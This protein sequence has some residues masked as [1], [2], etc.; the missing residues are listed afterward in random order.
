MAMLK[1]VKI[2]PRKSCN[3]SI[4]SQKDIEAAQKSIANAVSVAAEKPQS[5]GKYNSYS[6][7]QF[8]LKRTIHT[9]KNNSYSKEQRAM[10]GNYAAEN[11][12]T[13]A[14]KHYSAVWG[15]PINESTARRLK[16]E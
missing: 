12:P 6:K 3:S 9:Q 16:E 2:E 13:C 7:E 10:I 5:R 1:Y 11:G 4:L 8:I 15:I 14:A